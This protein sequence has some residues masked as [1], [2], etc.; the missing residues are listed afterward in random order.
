MIW[1]RF[2]RSRPWKVDFRFLGP[3]FKDAFKSGDGFV[4]ANGTKKNPNPLARSLFGTLFARNQLAGPKKG[5]KRFEHWDTLLGQ[6][7]E[8]F[9]SVWAP[10]VWPKRRHSTHPEL[11]T[12]NLDRAD[13]RHVLSRAGQVMGM[14]PSVLCPA[15]PFWYFLMFSLAAKVFV[16][17]IGCLKT[18]PGALNRRYQSQNDIWKFSKPM[19]FHRIFEF[20]FKE[21]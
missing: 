14:V 10:K 17:T 16:E 21:K 3:A 18:C 2:G 12:L 8:G 15:G 19:F 4:Y 13:I 11:W 6:V 5:S 20:H 1:T 7:F 9:D